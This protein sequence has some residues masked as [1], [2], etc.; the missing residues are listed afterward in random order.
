MTT[1]QELVETWKVVTRKATSGGKV[2]NR[3]ST[4]RADA[5]GR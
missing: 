1:N 4:G 5:D 2:N 3:E